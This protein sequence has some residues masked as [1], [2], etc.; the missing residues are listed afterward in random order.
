LLFRIVEQMGKSSQTRDNSSIQSI[1]RAAAI[2]RCFTEH[3]PELAL[4]ELSRLTQLHKST[5]ARILATLQKEGFVGKNV[6]TGKYRLGVGLISLAG[7]ALGRLDVR[8]AAYNFVET[9]V[10]HTQESA[11]VSVLED[12]ETVIILHTPSP[13]PVRYVNWIGR[14]LPLHCT[15]SGKILLSGMDEEGR[16][17]ALAGTLRRYTD[18]T[19]VD[20]DTLAKE[21]EQVCSQGIALALEEHE[22]GYNAIAAPIRN[23]DG[24]VVGAI[25]VSGPAFRLPAE[26]LLG[27]SEVLRDTAIN[28]SAEMGYRAEGGA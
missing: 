25:S 24:N 10:Q 5:V 11:S 26:T 22:Q 18:H 8:G 16:A 19:I 27:F 20:P 23:L 15:A 2:M 13:K 6:T 7:V 14:R 28:V 12:R 9:L 17:R 21:L 3:E 1:E 4:T